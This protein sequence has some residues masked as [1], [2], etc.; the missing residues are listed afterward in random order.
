MLLLAL[1]ML[2]FWHQKLATLHIMHFFHN[3]DFNFGLNVSFRK[4]EREKAREAALQDL[5]KLGN[6]G[7]LTG[8]EIVEGEEDEEE[9]VFGETYDKTEF[10][11]TRRNAT[12]IRLETEQNLLIKRMEVATKAFDEDLMGT[13]WSKLVM[14]H[15]QNFCELRVNRDF[16]FHRYHET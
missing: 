13:V 3:N 15:D 10:E 6:L 11:D 1:K 5:S 9:E 8:L 4:K 12:T 2:L 14:G 7:A 16:T